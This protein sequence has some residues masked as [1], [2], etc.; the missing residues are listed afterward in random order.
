[1]ESYVCPACHGV[2]SCARRQAHDAS[3]CPALEQRNRPG[4]IDG[5]VVEDEKRHRL[6]P[7]KWWSVGGVR[8]L[9]SPLCQENVV[10]TLG[11][12][13][14]LVFNFEQRDVS[15]HSDTGG[16]LWY[17]DRVMAEYLV[18]ETMLVNSRLSEAPLGGVCDGRPAA[19]SGALGHSVLV[20][21]C[22]GAPLSGL[23]ASVLG[24]DVVLTDL[25]EVLPQA[26]RNVELNRDVIQATRLGTDHRAGPYICV[27]ALPFGDHAALSAVLGITESEVQCGTSDRRL[28]VLCSDCMWQHKLHRPQLETIAA[29]LRRAKRG[30]A[31]AIVSYQARDPAIEELF[32][33]IAREEFGL[34]PV[35]VDLKHVLPLVAWPAQVR[36]ICRADPTYL[37]EI[38]LIYHL[39]LSEETQLISMA[40]DSL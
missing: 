5:E 40:E 35:R 29:A 22:G 8:A 25:V 27:K 39:T 2:V 17:A 3:W 34:V 9:L 37:T 28:L 38:F 23:V 18:F 10:V 14:G 12:F 7:K 26:Q 19:L 13:P 32:F 36:E 6:G 21:G 30:S 15:G 31:S 20:L 24:W 16:A 4:E 1:M 33:Q 11:S